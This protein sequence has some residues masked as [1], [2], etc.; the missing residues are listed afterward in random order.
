[1][2]PREVIFEFYPVGSYMKC[3]AVCTDTGIEV[4]VMGPANVGET[5]LKHTA[6]RKLE[7]VMAK[8]RADDPVPDRWQGL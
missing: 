5:A 6:L 3:S 8:R 2:L 4:S 7:Y 1:M